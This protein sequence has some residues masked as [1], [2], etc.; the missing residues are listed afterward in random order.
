[1]K[2]NRTSI[3]AILLIIGCGGL[4]Y[5]LVNNQT[6][7]IVKQQSTFS[8]MPGQLEYIQD[9][10]K[11]A[12]YYK[13]DSVYISS[14]QKIDFNNKE[15]SKASN[16]SLNEL[17]DRISEAEDKIKIATFAKTHKPEE[18]AKVQ[19]I[20]TK[21]WDLNRQM[22]KALKDNNIEL[23]QEI[24]SKF[25]EL[26]SPLAAQVMKIQVPEPIIK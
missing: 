1:M 15:I 21:A 9:L 13:V 20:F 24:Q 25:T 26:E 11:K 3:I 18:N 19:A 4:V 10:V 7:T 2:I 23:A 12:Q 5:G 8:Y 22:Y 17:E 14:V 16:N 6:T